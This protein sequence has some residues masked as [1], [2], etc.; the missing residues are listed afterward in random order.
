[1]T[2]LGPMKTR[3]P[4]ETFLPITTPGDIEALSLIFVFGPKV[5]LPG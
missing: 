2:V 1:M 3:S 5:Y 4:I